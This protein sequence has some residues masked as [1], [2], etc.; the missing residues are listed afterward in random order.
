MQIKSGLIRTPTLTS[1]LLFQQRK[2]LQLFV[3]DAAYLAL[4]KEK[5]N[6]Y[7]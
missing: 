7:W 1:E 2:F 6:T 3:D 4:T 5:Q